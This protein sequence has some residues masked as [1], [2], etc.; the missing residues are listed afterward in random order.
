[1]DYASCDIRVTVARRD[2]L[3]ITDIFET[4]ASDIAADWFPEFARIN[5][6][7]HVAFVTPAGVDA[8]NPRLHVR[9]V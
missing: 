7:D 6:T 5:Q 4:N 9:K 3:E 2:T 1:M 8:A